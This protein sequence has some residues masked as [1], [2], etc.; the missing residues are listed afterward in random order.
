MLLILTSQRG[1]L[2][3]SMLEDEKGERMVMEPA[4]WYFFCVTTEGALT[5]D[6]R[7][8]RLALCMNR[9][10]YWACRNSAENYS[11][12]KYQSLLLHPCENV[13]MFVF[14]L[15]EDIFSVYRKIGV[16]YSGMLWYDNCMHKLSIL[17][18]SVYHTCP[19]V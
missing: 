3:N 5:A 12:V 17:L 6:K 2:E 8:S 7:G 16:L 13:C 4:F 9:S 11:T 14:C 1:L 15:T 10:K 19:L 18:A